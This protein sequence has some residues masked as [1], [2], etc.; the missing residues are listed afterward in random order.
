MTI[1]NISPKNISLTNQTPIFL[2]DDTSTICA[3][4]LTADER[5]WCKYALANDDVGALSCPEF[6]RE[7]DDNTNTWCGLN[8][9][10]RRS[11]C[12]FDEPQTAPVWQR[13]KSYL[14]KCRARGWVL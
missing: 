5:Q 14:A 9:R 10:D 4:P 11:P 1:E 6:R 7:P 12:V 13:I 3:T 8:G 2:I